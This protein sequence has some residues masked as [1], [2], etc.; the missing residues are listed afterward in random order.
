MNIDITFKL[1]LTS[2]SVGILP[3]RVASLTGF[4]AFFVPEIESFIRSSPSDITGTVVEVP[5]MV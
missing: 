1:L 3:L 5:G 2:P 4:A